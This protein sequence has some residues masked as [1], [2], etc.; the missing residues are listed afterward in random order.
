[1]THIHPPSQSSDIQT[2]ETRSPVLDDPTRKYVQYVL[3]SGLAEIDD[4]K[5]IVAS[6]LVDSDQ[7]SPERISAGLVSAGILTPWQAKKILA[8]R[9]RGFFL[10]GY[11]LLRPLGK[12]GM[13]VVY[14]AEHEVMKRLMAL[15]IL[16]QEATNNPKRIAQ[17]KQEARAAAQLDHQNIVRAYDF[18]ETDGKFFIVME[19]VDGID[20][21]HAVVRDAAM[22]VPTA[23]DIMAQ[24]ASGLA[25]AHDRGV[26]HRD[27]KPGN[28]MLRTDGVVKISDM[29]LARMGWSGGGDEA[30]KR[31][32]GTAD[33]VAPEQVI[34]SRTADARSDIYSLGCTVFYL[35]TGRTA[36]TGDT[37]NQRLAQHQTAP[38]PD[39]RTYCACPSP[40]LQI[41]FA[42]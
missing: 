3:A 40:Q 32:M 21:H 17:F 10:G 7:F 35:L 24:A 33:F 16:P 11:R 25:H 26:V 6:L 42:E 8:G 28:L 30:E 2:S 38:V 23:M 14:L 19:Y 31:F 13:G 41:C 9:N 12:G 15:K 29:G 39:V 5:K 18:A 22:S 4:I 20:L 36:F 1:M 34:D 27:I 37:V